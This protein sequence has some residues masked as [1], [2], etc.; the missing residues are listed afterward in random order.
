MKFSERWSSMLIIEAMT[1]GRA[2]EPSSYH[3]LSWEACRSHVAVEV[4]VLSK[5]GPLNRLLEVFLGLL[6]TALQG[7][8]LALIF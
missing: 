1:T 3:D 5:T 4:R 8:G 2:T 6:G 7:L